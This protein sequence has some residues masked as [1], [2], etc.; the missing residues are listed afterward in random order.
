MTDMLS[1]INNAAGYV[2][3]LREHE[4]RM[5]ERENDLEKFDQLQHADIHQV[6]F[7]N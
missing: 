4:D 6:T 3:D 5:I 7:L 2:K 1:K